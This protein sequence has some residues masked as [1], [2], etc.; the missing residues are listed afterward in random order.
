MNSQSPSPE[1]PR[2]NRPDREGMHE[3][4]KSFEQAQ[5]I[6]AEVKKLSDE[7]LRVE[8][9]RRHDRTLKFLMALA[10]VGITSAACW[11]YFSQKPS[12]STVTGEI[13]DPIGL[14]ADEQITAEARATL[15]SFF[16][17]PDTT[18]RCQFILEP[19]RVGPI[20]D[21]YY[22]NGGSDTVGGASGFSRVPGLTGDDRARNVL[23]MANSTGAKEQKALVIYLK[24]VDATWRMDWEAYVQN[25]DLVLVDFFKSS[26]HEPIIARAGLRRVHVFG[27]ATNKEALHV[28]QLEGW[29][30]S[31]DVFPLPEVAAKINADLPWSARR[32]AVMALA[33]EPNATGKPHVVCRELKSWDFV[34]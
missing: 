3:V 5:E 26:A 11:F 34:P 16:A 19:E 15:E 30:F 8:M 32:R 18:S 12:P 21:Q 27:S 10:F 2:Y 22:K 14:K 28:I 31:E 1:S 6:Y 20:L 23:L 9:S 29:E 13:N 4:T 33:W 7:E 25:K 24:K 17:A